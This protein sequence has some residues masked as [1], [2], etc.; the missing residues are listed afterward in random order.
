MSPQRFWDAKR[1]FTWL[2]YRSNSVAI[3][4]IA[5]VS[6]RALKPTRLTHFDAVPHNALG[7]PAV[8]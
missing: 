3:G 5:D 1:R 7:V 2:L 6:W 8:C 4:G